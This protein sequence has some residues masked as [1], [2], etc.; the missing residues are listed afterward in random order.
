LIKKKTVD[1]EIKNM[2][3]ERIKQIMT[4]ESQNW[5]NPQNHNFLNDNHLIPSNIYDETDYYLRL[6]EEANLVAN[7]DFEELEKLYDDKQQLSIKNQYLI[8][9]FSDVKSSLKHL[10][11]TKTGRLEKEFDLA[12]AIFLQ[13]NPD[14][15]PEER[16][17]KLS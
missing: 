10:K 12:K 16:A 3:K 11:N 13:E 8:P 4:I 7:G 15:S 17:N 6:T 5:W 9:L 1:E 2:N 14:L